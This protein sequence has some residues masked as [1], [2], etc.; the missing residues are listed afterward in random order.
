MRVRST[1]KASILVSLL[2]S[3]LL[4]VWHILDNELSAGTIGKASILILAWLATPLATTYIGIRTSNSITVWV[5]FVIMILLC[6]I[7]LGWAWHG[8]SREF[9]LGGGHLHLFLLPAF[10]V[11]AVPVLGM[12][13][14]LIA[15][16]CVRILGTR[17]LK[18][19]ANQS[20]P[21]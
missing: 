8:A 5:C 15:L 9:E 2:F 20:M 10:L 7:F 16:I 18:R 13:L 3:F 11:V 14:Y 6:S 21:S 1:P 4:V 12:F 19:D 17:S